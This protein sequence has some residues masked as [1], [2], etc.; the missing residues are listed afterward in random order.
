MNEIESTTRL[1]KEQS[2]H[3][4]MQYQCIVDTGVV[5]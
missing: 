5:T 4:P 3:I 2:T 1:I